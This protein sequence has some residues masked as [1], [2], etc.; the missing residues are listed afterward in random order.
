MQQPSKS[1]HFILKTDV[2]ASHGVDANLLIKG[3]IFYLPIVL[4]RDVWTYKFCR[5]ASPLKKTEEQRK[6]TFWLQV[7]S[8]ELG[9]FNLSSNGAT[10]TN[11]K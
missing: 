8:R 3:I 9:I 1:N 5:V 7:V 11:A 2:K 4:Y 10:I 6:I